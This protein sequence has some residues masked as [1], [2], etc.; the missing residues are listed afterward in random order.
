MLTIKF[1][2]ARQRCRVVLLFKKGNNLLFTRNTFETERHKMF[3]Y[4]DAIKYSKQLWTKRKL[5]INHNSLKSE[6]QR[7]M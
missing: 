4:K 3:K 7:M 6:E 2:T 5:G 1:T